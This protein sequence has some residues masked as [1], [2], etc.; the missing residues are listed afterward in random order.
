ME[1]KEEGAALR[2]DL[3]RGI[4][5]C[6][7]CV[8]STMPY[9][10]RAVGPFML[11]NTHT[12]TYWTHT[13]FPPSPDFISQTTCRALG[14]IGCPF[15]LLMARG[16]ERT[17]GEIAKLLSFIKNLLLKTYFHICFHGISF[18]LHVSRSVV[19]TYCL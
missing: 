19:L 15:S 13:H 17:G 16:E 8:F 14:V 7:Q 2:Y 12:H 9:Q 1:G 18:I 6:V 10:L 3:N 5:V 4:G 11:R